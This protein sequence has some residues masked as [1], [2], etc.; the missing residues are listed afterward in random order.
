MSH[1]LL[2]QHSSEPV[3]PHP[4]DPSFRQDWQDSYRVSEV[5]RPQ[6][7]SDDRA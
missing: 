1:R 5:Y 2:E 3:G 7:M 6:P 4:D